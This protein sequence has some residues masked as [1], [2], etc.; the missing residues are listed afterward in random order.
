MDIMVR[1]RIGW[2]SWKGRDRMDIRV[3]KRYD[4]Y[5]GKENNRIDTMVRKRI[6]WIS[7]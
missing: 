5:H 7:W 6:G 3:R 4:G 1:K 2:I